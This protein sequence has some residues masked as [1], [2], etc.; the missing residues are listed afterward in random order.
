MLRLLLLLLALF[1]MPKG[2]NAKEVTCPICK[3]TFKISDNLE[4]E[5]V[6]DCSGVSG[7]IH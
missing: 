1:L 3:T 5:Q 4:L 7:F 2:I 6:H